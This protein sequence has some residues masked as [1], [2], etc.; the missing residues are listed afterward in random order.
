MVTVGHVG[1]SYHYQRGRVK[2]G[3]LH[4]TMELVYLNVGQF[5]LYRVCEHG[6]MELGTLKQHRNIVKYM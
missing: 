5:T 4:S 3:D 2:P 6:R 1:D